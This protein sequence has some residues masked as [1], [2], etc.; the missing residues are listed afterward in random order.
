LKPQIEKVSLGRMRGLV[1]SSYVS[2][3]WLEILANP[4]SLFELP[5][6]RIVK[7]SPTTKAAVVTVEVGGAGHALHVKRLNRRGMDFTVKYLFQ[8][9]RARRLFRNH[10]ALIE[11]GVPTL[12]PIAA[13]SERAGPFL[14]SSFLIT[15]QIEAKPLFTLWEK[16]LYPSGNSPERRRKLMTDVA[17]LVAKMHTAGVF[18]RD[19]KSSNI[20]V[21]TDGR[22]VIAD[23]DGARM[24]SS[25]SY[26]QRVRDL[27][28]LSTSLVPLANMADRHVFLKEYIA[29]FG[30]GDNLKQMG[31]DIAL[32]GLRIL[33]S[34][35]LKGKYEDQE[36]RYLD[37]F[38]E[39]QRRWLKSFKSGERRNSET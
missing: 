1:T 26:R 33:R 36:Y 28:R 27:A 32:K 31:R 2:P 29:A 9:S 38:A 4:D 24:R 20:L 34:K 5:A 16:D 22:P 8:C 13:I 18:H 11:R 10:V 3:E 15:K 14:R 37:D 12:Q 6:A 30:A 21:K 25:V 19:L 39:R 7:D 17:L 23:L 35:R